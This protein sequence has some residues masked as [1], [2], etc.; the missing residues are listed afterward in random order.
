MGH[1]I[2]DN[3]IS[4]MQ[5]TCTTKNCMLMEITNLGLWNA[6]SWTRIPIPVVDKDSL[7]TKQKQTRGLRCSFPVEGPPIIGFQ[8]QHRSTHTTALQKYGPI[9]NLVSAK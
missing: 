7:K 5:Q 2:Y 3:F 1:L 6:N 4:L 8:P 9:E